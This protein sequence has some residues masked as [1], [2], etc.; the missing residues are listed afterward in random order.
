M[1]TINVFRPDAARAMGHAF[2]GVCAS[3]QIPN[4]AVKAREMIAKRIL[5]LGGQGEH[6]YKHLRDRVLNEANYRKFGQTSEGAVPNGPHDC[7]LSQLAAGSPSSVR[8]A[9]RKEVSLQPVC[10]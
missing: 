2:D 4:R 5:E 9:C 6:E 10:V 3:L 7:V 8:T 1:T